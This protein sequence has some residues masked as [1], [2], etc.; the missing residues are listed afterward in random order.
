MTIPRE[1]AGFDTLLSKL[2]LEG[3]YG[4]KP[5]LPDPGFGQD[6]ALVAF[7]L[8]NLRQQLADANAEIE[9]LRADYTEAVRLYRERDA[10]AARYH[11]R[12]QIDPGGSDRIDELE[13]AIEHLRADQLRPEYRLDYAQAKPNRYVDAVGTTG[14]K[15]TIERL[16]P[17]SLGE[18]RR[19]VAAHGI[20][21]VRAALDAIEHE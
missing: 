12:L 15:V 6:V 3:L 5:L 7:T 4:V 1:H 14:G 2:A 13:A 19:I 21:R 17:M 20:T 10:Q 9:R 11:D 8:D 16:N 18:L